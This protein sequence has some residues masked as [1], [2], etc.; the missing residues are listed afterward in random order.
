MSKKKDEDNEEIIKIVLVGNSTVGKTSIIDR[1]DRD[2]FSEEMLS[3]F[4][5]N[6]ISKYIKVNDKKVRLDLWDTAGQEQ[7][8][9]LGKLFVKNSKIII[10][11]YDIT[12]K[13]SFDGLDFWYDFIQTELGYKITLG[14]VGN[15]A[16]LFE[17]EK[18]STE[19]AEQK[20]KN[21]NAYFSLLSAKEDKPGIDKYFN[22]I[23]KIY[24]ENE[25]NSDDI[26]RKN[27]IKIGKHN[28]LDKNN[29]CCGGGEKEKEK[30]IK[31]AF[32]GG[33]GV[34]KSNIINVI[35]GKEIKKKYEHTKKTKI[36]KL[37]YHL[38]DNKKIHINILDTNGDDCSDSEFKLI[39][40][41]CK[42]FFLV[43]DINN[44]NSFIQLD[45]L[46]KK[47]QSDKNGNKII[48]ILGNK[49]NLPDGEHGSMTKE[50]IEIFTKENSCH[51]ESVSINEKDSI[52]NIFRKCFENYLDSQILY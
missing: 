36:K 5:S 31:V 40:E 37:I 15:K 47:I 32:L 11:V 14:L 46:V 44:K 6:F 21:W 28:N 3:T 49:T 45:N 29:D 20:A 35:R 9:A 16:D 12:N 1:F 17:E 39:L 13:S 30:G 4:G 48:N 33:N 7:Y 10:L 19:I 23:T 42:I 50:E 51:Y 41:E 26:V 8:R 2:Y 24:L 18:V 38:K 34:G 22:E 43:F 27:S 25:D 52:Q